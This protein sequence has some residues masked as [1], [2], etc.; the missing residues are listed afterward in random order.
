MRRVIPSWLNQVERFFGLLT[1]RRIRRGTFGSVRELES[2]S[3]QPKL[4]ALFL[5]REGRHHN[6]KKRSPAFVC[7]LLIRD[8][9]SRCLLRLRQSRRR[10]EPL[11][12]AA[13]I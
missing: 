8:T 1:D 13:R 2:D 3:S 4:Q 6:Q 11:K 12:L 9:S 5:D 10:S 7:E